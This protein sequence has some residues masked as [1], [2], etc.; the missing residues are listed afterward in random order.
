V[1]GHVLRSFETD[2]TGAVD[3]NSGASEVNHRTPLTERWGGWY[4]TG[5]HG[6]QTHRGNLIGQAAFARQQR[7]PN[8]LG[9]LTDLSRFF[10]TSR[11]PEP[12]SDIVA[13][14]VLEHQTHMHNFITRLNDEATLMLHTYGH[15]NY[16]KSVEESFLKYLL[17]TEE[18]PLTA[19]I[20]GNSGFTRTFENLGPRDH[21]G[22]SLRQF[23]L[24]TRL[25][26]YPCS[27]LIYSEAFD[28]LPEKMKEQIYGRLWGILNGRD[29]EIELQRIPRSTRRA[30]LEILL[31]TKPG[32]PDYWKKS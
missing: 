5:T 11:Y 12:T 21:L 18:T 31:E 7:E 6:M 30:I 2:E 22:R 1:P 27:Y 16:L 15:V 25:F 4:V 14:M 26:K 28:R 24:R 32:L 17:F 9:N 19:P 10:E 3:L 8:Y 29:D 20:R 23:D 13:L